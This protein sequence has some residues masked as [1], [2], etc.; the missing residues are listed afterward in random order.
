MLR[1]DGL[2]CQGCGYDLTGVL[3]GRPRARCPE[4]GREATVEESRRRFL[5][6]GWY[7][8]PLVMIVGGSTSILAAL[9]ASPGA[10]APSSAWFGAA[11]LGGVGATVGGSVL[12]CCMVQWRSYVVGWFDRGLLSGLALGMGVSAALAMFEHACLS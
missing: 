10:V 11:L 2:I 1:F 8:V 7:A 12:L 5:P 4:C 3:V 9:F 6:G